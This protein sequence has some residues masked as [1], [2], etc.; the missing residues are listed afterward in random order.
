MWTDS[1]RL[2]E[3]QIPGG[4]CVNELGNP[5]GG[6]VWGDRFG[7]RCQSPRHNLFGTA[8]TD[9]RPQ[10]STPFQPTG[11]PGRFEGSPSWQSQTGRVRVMESL[12]RSC[13]DMTA[14]V[15]GPNGR[16]TTDEAT[17]HG[18]CSQRPEH[19]CS[20]LVLFIHNASHAQSTH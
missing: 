8:R 18:S 10:R 3:S 11:P 16:R 7:D 1:S 6:P 17:K 15:W 12:V 19:P 20:C 13:L 4:P 5:F 9:C 14:G 2:V